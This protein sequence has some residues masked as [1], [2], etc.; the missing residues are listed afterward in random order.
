MI[1]DLLCG[2]SGRK[3]YRF[4]LP[5]NNQWVSCEL[6]WRGSMHGKTLQVLT[7][8]FTYNRSYWDFPFHPEEYSFVESAIEVGYVTLSYDRLGTGQSSVRTASE[9]TIRSHARVLN[10]I[11][12]AARYGQIPGMRHKFRRIV[13]IGHSIGSAIAIRQA[14]LSPGSVDKLILTSTMQ[15]TNPLFQGIPTYPAVADTK[16]T[17]WPLSDH[18]VTSQF[19]QRHIFFYSDKSDTRVQY[20]DE[21]LKDVGALT[22]FQTI[23]QAY[24]SEIMKRIEIPVQYVIGSEDFLFCDNDDGPMCRRADDILSRIREQ[25]LFP[26]SPSVRA[27]IIPGAGHSLNLHLNARKT[28]HIINEESHRPA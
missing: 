22:E 6:N 9:R 3:T 18:V 19:G 4:L 16:F 15:D 5:V 2:E 7:P 12:E 25:G 21:G 10:F 14:G 27:N 13:S 11:V 1:F 28:F 26:R 8:G 24:S 17:D 23:H 20:V